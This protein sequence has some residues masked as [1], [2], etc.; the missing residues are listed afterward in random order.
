VI[1]A[2]ERI[3]N[4]NTLRGVY[5]PRVSDHVGLLGVYESAPSVAIRADPL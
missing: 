3:F 2:C 1:R 4:R 5:Y